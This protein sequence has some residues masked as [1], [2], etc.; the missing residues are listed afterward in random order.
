M[1]AKPT[2]SSASRSDL[3]QHAIC[4][5]LAPDRRLLEDGCG[6]ADC[7]HCSHLDSASPDNENVRDIPPCLLGLQHHTT[8]GYDGLH[9]VAMMVTPECGGS[10]REQ[11]WEAISTI[12]AILRQQSEPMTVTVQTVFLADANDAPAARQ[13]FEA[14]YGEEMPL[15]LFVGQPPCGGVAIA[16]EAWAISTR[17]VSVGYHG[18]HLVTVEHDG[19]R[20]IHASAGSLNLGNRIA[21]EQSAA[22]FAALGKV[23]SAFHASFTDVVRVW[24]YQGNITEEEDDGTERYR[25]LNRAR[26]DFFEQYDFGSNPLAAAE[27]GHAIYPASTGIGTLEHGLIT[28]CLAVQ[29]DRKDVSILSLENPQQTSAFEYPKEYSRKSPKFSRAMAMRIG[30]HLTT[31]VSGTASIVN[32]ETMH[33]GDVEKQTEQTLDNIE[34]L[35]APENFACQGW[36]DA[37]ATL[38]D[39]AKVR[40]Y[41]KHSKDFEACR[42]VCER[43][44]GRIPAIYAQAD[45]CRPDLLVEIEG[46]AFSSLPHRAHEHSDH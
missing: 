32:A 4:Y 33:P 26:T 8:I 24:L 31:W 44:L 12:R 7:Q 6:A 43:R 34:K 37:G 35:I 40:V 20:W 2:E 25:E 36:A 14:Y 15:T 28:T 21:Y 38:A 23:L 11:A 10:F 46:V 29:T 42:S 1:S 39:L 9:R 41:V 5:R 18:P 16:I 19:I 17:T 30:N 22:A 3:S 13:L 45:I 27:H